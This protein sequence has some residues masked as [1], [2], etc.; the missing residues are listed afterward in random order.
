VTWTGTRGALFM[1]VGEGG[2]PVSMTRRTLLRLVEE[3]LVRAVDTQ[4]AVQ[5][6]IDAIASAEPQPAAA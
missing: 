6:A 4:D 2:E 5:R 1:F 3:Q